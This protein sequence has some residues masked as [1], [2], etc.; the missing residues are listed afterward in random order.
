MQLLKQRHQALDF[1]YE[2]K[3]KDSTF[4]QAYLWTL[5]IDTHYINEEV[6]KWIKF[7]YLES[8]FL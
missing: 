5:D 4:K 7:A 6:I 2:D 3:E 8:F 1:I